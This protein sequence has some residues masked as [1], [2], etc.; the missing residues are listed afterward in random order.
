M[1]NKFAPQ[2]SFIS[3]S[4]HTHDITCKVCADKLSLV[5]NRRYDQRK[6]ARCGIRLLFGP[7]VGERNYLTI[8]KPSS[9]LQFY[10]SDRH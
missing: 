5:S 3:K 8:S 4:A 7:K 9:T 2:K 10:S 1:Y 6:T